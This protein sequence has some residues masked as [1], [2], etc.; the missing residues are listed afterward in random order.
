MWMKQK[1]VRKKIKEFPSFSQHA[2]CALNVEE[3]ISKV[4]VAKFERLK[5]QQP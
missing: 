3:R 2:V 4:H 5:K 1:W